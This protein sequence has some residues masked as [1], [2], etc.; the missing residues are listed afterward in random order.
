MLREPRLNSQKALDRPACQKRKTSWWRG[1]FKRLDCRGS[2]RVAH[3]AAVQ[4]FWRDRFGDGITNA[5]SL[6]V[7]ASGIAIKCSE[8]IPLKMR[9]NV[10]MG[11]KGVSKGV[12]RYCAPQDDG[13]LVGLELKDVPLLNIS[14]RRSAIDMATEGMTW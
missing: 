14:R 5:V 12:V 4:V 7:S 11:S 6:N 2:E 10:R 1:I 13:Y 3:H 9:V 8:P